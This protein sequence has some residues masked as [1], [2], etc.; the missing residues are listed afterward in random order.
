VEDR[1][2]APADPDGGAAAEGRETK[3]TPY[4]EH[5]PGSTR[6]QKQA[7]TIDTTLQ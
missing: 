5:V 6:V 3:H 7:K 2:S 1:V 4:G